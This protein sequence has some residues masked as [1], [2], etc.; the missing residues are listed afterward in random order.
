LVR[1]LVDAQL[2]SALAR[3]LTAHGH[4]AQH[5]I[6]IGMLSARDQDIWRLA[7][8]TDAILVTKDE[9]FAQLHRR[10][11]GPVVIWLR[12]GN[13][14]RRALLAWLE[15]LLPEIEELVNRGERLIELR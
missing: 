10:T 14:T 3:M 4:E 6:D 5:V 1:F 15:P 12:V 2:P 8:E 11:A 13:T 9:D 7:E